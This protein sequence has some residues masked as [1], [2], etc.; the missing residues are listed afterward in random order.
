MALSRDIESISRRVNNLELPKSYMRIGRFADYVA[1]FTEEATPIV[2]E[3]N[4]T[5]GHFHTINV[6]SVLR[7]RP[8]RG[9]FL[10][11]NV[12]WKEGDVEVSGE[13]I[14][15]PPGAHL[16]IQGRFYPG[17]HVAGDTLL[18]LFVGGFIFGF[19]LQDE[20]G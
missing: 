6:G 8:P 13:A 14:L 1:G 18:L 3:T 10:K 7:I 4:F 16:H 5:E 19:S 17:R 20:V 15:T 9:R 12:F 2:V 11:G